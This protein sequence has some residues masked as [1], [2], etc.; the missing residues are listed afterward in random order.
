MAKKDTI[1]LKDDEGSEIVISDDKVVLKDKDG[2]VVK[3][4]FSLDRFTKIVNAVEF[5]LFLIAIATYIVLGNLLNL[6]ANMWV[7]LFVPGIICSFIRAVHKRNPQ[8]FNV[9]FTTLFVYFFV[10]L[11]FPGPDANLWHP[12]WVI[13]FAIPLYHIIVSIFRRILR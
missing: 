3:K 9:L 8:H 1:K 4:H 11:T 7:I 10:C 6:W 12:L 2:K 5:G 13:F